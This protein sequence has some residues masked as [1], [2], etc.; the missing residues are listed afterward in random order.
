[1]SAPATKKQFDLGLFQV[2]EHLQLAHV[3]TFQR[4]ALAFAIDWGLI[5]L[6]TQYVGALILILV[7]Y[8]VFTKHFGSTVKQVN[9][10]LGSGL[11]GLDNTLAS[12]DLE[13]TLRSQLR[14]VLRLSAYGLML[15]LIA[16][17]VFGLGVLLAD[18]LAHDSI[19]HITDQ[20]R[21]VDNIEVVAPWKD[22]S[23][24]VG[25]ITKFMGAIGYFT[26]FPHKWNG[27]TPGKRLMRIRAVRLNGQ[28]LTFYNWFERASG[29]ASSASMLLLGF[30][31]Y[32]WDR[33]HQTTHDKLVETVVIEQDI[34]QV[35]ATPRAALLALAERAR[36]AQSKQPAD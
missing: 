20:W 17:P 8:L 33:N 4:R 26:I 25:I 28:P 14:G 21:T 32:F 36:L 9:H 31:Q 12:Y 6:A 10:L 19:K 22:L 2:A 18:A 34:P 24:A 27:Q 16:V 3:A 5:Y 1:M 15:L 11:N 13:A 7:A 29:Y 23:S 30:F 35:E